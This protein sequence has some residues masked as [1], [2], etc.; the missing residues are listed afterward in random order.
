MKTHRDYQILVKMDRILSRKL[1]LQITSNENFSNSEL[2]CKY[3]NSWYESAHGP[4]L[5]IIVVYIIK[6]SVAILKS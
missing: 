6:A 5:N 3:F 1:R 2:P 4:Y